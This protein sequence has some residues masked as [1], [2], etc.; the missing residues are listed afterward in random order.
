MNIFATNLDPQVCAMEHCETHVTKQILEN[1][2]ILSTV[3]RKHSR[4][5]ECDGLYK[6]THENHPVVIWAGETKANYQWLVELTEA[7]GEVYR[8]RKGN[9]HL[10]EQK[11]LERL[12][13]A[14]TRLPSGG[15]TKH[16]LCLPIDITQKNNY[17]VEA[18]YKDYLNG[19][20]VEW[21]QRDKPIIPTWRIEKP[22]WISPVT[23]AML[24]MTNK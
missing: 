6:K 21:L 22:S 20:F 3:T 9:T 7:L 4:D 18:S 1:Y 11:L 8:L 23:D 17:D 5:S 24:K 13:D 2:Q 15:L 12:S 19:K 10:S 14:P 16:A